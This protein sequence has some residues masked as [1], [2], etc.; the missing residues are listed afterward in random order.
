RLRVRG[1][2]HVPQVLLRLRRSGVSVTRLTILMYHRVDEAP[3]DAA[4]PKNFVSPE[5]FK[6]QIE[7]L[8]SWGYSP[9][10]LRQWMTYR[11]HRGHIPKN[12]FVV[13]FDD[14]Y[15]DFATN[16]WPVLK[17]LGVP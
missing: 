7:G 9:V 3:W 12:P 2:R 1:D 5:R 16:A 10:T 15:L 14:G 13:T 6:E 8:L 17:S 11:T 4:H